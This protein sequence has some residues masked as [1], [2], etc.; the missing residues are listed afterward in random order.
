MIKITSFI[1]AAS[2]FAPTSQAYETTDT[3]SADTGQI[4]FSIDDPLSHVTITNKATGYREV[5]DGAVSNL[6]LTVAPGTYLI[7]A[8]PYAVDDLKCK[9]VISAYEPWNQSPYYTTVEVEIDE[10]LPVSVW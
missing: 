1:L 2:L 3:Y 6:A 5:V 4:V 9:P 8:A 10:F 7:K